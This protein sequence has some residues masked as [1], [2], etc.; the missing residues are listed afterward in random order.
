MGLLLMVA[1][2]L[3]QFLSPHL[4]CVLGWILTMVSNF[5][6]NTFLNIFGFV[7]NGIIEVVE[8]E[9]PVWFDLLFLSL[10]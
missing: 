8:F 2:F 9:I 10:D 4:Q 6:F 3:F 5:I 7:L 1:G